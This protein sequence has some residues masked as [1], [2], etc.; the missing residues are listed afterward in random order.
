VTWG[1]HPK[2]VTKAAR[3][4]DLPW[5]FQLTTAQVSDLEFPTASHVETRERSVEVRQVSKPNPES[6]RG[7]ALLDA[8]WIYEQAMRA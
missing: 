4:T 6:N 7:D 2:P 1:R 5:R 3:W 8:A